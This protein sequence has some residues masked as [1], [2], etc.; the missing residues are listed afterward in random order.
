M[1]DHSLPYIGL[2]MRLPTLDD[3]P[4]Y[5]LP[6]NYDLRWFQSGDEGPWAEIEVSAG[7]F[8]NIQ[9]ALVGFRRSYPNEEDLFERMFFLTDRGVPFATATAWYGDGAFPPCEGRLHWVAIDSA[10]Q[11]R[12]LSYPLVSLALERIKALGH[13]TVYLTTQTNSWPAVKVYHRFGF[14]PV[15]REEAEIEGW[16]IVSEKTG[17][18]FL[19]DLNTED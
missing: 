15:L 4:E 17:I 9:D 6:E 18:N 11:R 10:H 16:R 3:L 5:A 8:D 13:R 14:V 2:V 7:E 12:G 19:T 1:I